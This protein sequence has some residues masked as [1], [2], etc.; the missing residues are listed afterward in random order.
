MSDAKILV[1]LAHPEL[2]KSRANRRIIE[3]IE[4]LTKVTVHDLYVEYPDFAIDVERE[5]QLLLESD[6]VVLQ[7]PFYWYSTPAL[8]K[9]WE[10]R[11][12]AYGFAYGSKGTALHGKDLLVSTTAGGNLDFYQAGGFNNYTMSEL[13]RPLQQTANLCGMHYLTP[14]VL[15]GVANIPGIKMEDIHA[16]NVEEHAARLRSFLDS[17]PQADSYDF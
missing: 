11:V 8:L 2:E 17:Y 3:E 15:H 16:Q 5:Q 9:E 12:L 6:L 1:L 7:F 4:P 10:D 13:L 14:F